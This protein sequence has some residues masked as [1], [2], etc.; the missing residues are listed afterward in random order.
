MNAI[1]WVKRSAVIVGLALCGLVLATGANAATEPVTAEVEFVA[2]VVIEET[3]ALQF[4]LLDVAIGSAETVIITPDGTVTDGSN[5]IQGGTQASGK[6]DVTAVDAKGI[7]I[8]VENVST[9]AGSGYALGP[10]QCDYDAG[11]DGD[12]GAGMNVTAGAGTKEVRVGVTL[13]GDGTAT[14]GVKNS[15][16][17]LTINYQ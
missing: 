17:D 12:C 7:T 4:G 10:W 13:T 15:T 11:E 9:P 1:N 14:P 16:F 2:A 3:N 8:L 6:F 5:N